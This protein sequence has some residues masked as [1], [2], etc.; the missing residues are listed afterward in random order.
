MVS[1][2][3][4]GC[5]LQNGNNAFFQPQQS[6]SQKDIVYDVGFSSIPMPDT[7]DECS[8]KYWSESNRLQ[9]MVNQ[10]TGDRSIIQPLQQKAFDWEYACHRKIDATKAEAKAKIALEKSKKPK[11][12]RVPTLKNYDLPKSLGL[13]NIFP[14]KW[15]DC[16]LY[17]QDAGEI[18]HYMI[19]FGESEV[20]RNMFRNGYNNES[21]TNSAKF[22]INAVQAQAELL[23]WHTDCR[24]QSDNINE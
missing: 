13:P 11:G 15:Q 4:S 8:S 10:G 3:S 6:P 14:A 20:S 23:R 5:A 1:L 24:N 12:A 16:M 2:V 7:H 19:H 21:Q 17:Y 22:S 9:T 18:L